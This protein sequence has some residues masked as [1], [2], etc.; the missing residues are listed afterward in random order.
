VGVVVEAAEVGPGAAAE[1]DAAAGAVAEPAQRVGLLAA[2]AGTER[3]QP[4]RQ[5]VRHRQGEAGEQERER[6]AHC[7]GWGGADGRVVGIGF[8]SFRVLVTQGGR[9][10]AWRWTG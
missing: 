7:R 8:G 2:G 4:A 5:R 10:W 3:G 1:A 9:L 6:A